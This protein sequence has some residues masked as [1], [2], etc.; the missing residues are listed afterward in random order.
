MESK[1]PS[2]TKNAILVLATAEISETAEK[3]LHIK[4]TD[5]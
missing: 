1:K 4:L 2:L 3:M 5:I